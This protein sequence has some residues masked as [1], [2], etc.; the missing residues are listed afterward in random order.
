MSDGS[1]PGSRTRR[2]RSDAEHNASRVVQAAHAVFA[3]QGTAATI[4]GVASRAGVGRAT[5]Y[6]SFPTR[7]SLVESMTA[8]RIEW[9]LARLRR[10][11]DTDDMTV[12]FPVFIHDVMLRVLDDR[13][14]GEVVAPPMEPGAGPS[15]EI[16][17]LMAE[18]V[19]RARRDGCVDAS[20]GHTDLGR[21]LAGLVLALVAQRETDPQQWHRAA[22]LVLR[23][24]R[25]G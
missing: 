5:V 20:L 3:E 7:A 4:E 11:L 6:R 21:L 1:R 24:C 22:D 9:M 23:A 2:R 14:L 13:V 17:D 12:E 16:A 8:E 19:D 18:L 10:A 15:A 25:N